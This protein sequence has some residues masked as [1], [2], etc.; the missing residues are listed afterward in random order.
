MPLPLY[1]VDAFTDRPFAGNPAGVCVL[2]RDAWPDTAWMQAVAAEVNLS[3]TAFVQPAPP[4]PEPPEDVPGA[5][6]KTSG[7]GGKNSG[8]GGEGRG[9]RYFTPRAEVEL[10]G[11]ATLASAHALWEHGGV[12]A[13][14]AIRFH[15]IADKML[16]CRRAADGQIAMDFPAHPPHDDEPPAGL[17]AAL[18][19]EPD[20]VFRLGP[21]WI[22]RLRDAAAVRSLA[23]D[24][25]ALAQLDWGQTHGVAVTGEGDAAP[26][27]QAVDFTS[28]FFAPAVGIAEDPVTG[29]AHC[30]LG[31]YWSARLGRTDLRAFQASVRGG[32]LRIHVDGPRVELRGHAVTTIVG[33]WVGT[34]A[35]D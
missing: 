28:R 19:V 7:A 5:Q 34:E 17:A 16:T 31:P 25:A 22:A 8:G 3:E 6:Q 14:T 32:V 24:H 35:P 33:Q 12:P 23:P 29:S 1:I 10:C 18:C 27:G 21:M 2:E 26:D 4:P 13:D 30:A 15:T 9:I 20:E 11:H